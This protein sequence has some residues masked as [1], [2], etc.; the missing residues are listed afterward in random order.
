M[1]KK[2]V[3]IIITIILIVLSS[4]IAIIG[5]N[6]KN[7]KTIEVEAVVKLIG[8]DY[9]VVEDDKGEKY[10]LETNDEYSIGDRVDFL[11]KKIKNKSN[12]IEGTLVK[13]DTI[14]KDIS[15]SINDNAS[16]QDEVNNDK[17]K[18]EED[19]S[20]NDN[21][22]NNTSNSNKNTYNDVSSNITNTISNDNAVITYLTNLNNE[23]EEYNQ[24]K[25]IGKRLKEGFVTV[26]DFLFYDGEIKG[27]TFDE[28]SNEAKIKVL[29][30]ALKIDSKID[31]YFPGYKEE[32]STTTKDVYTNFKSKASA[33]YLDITTKICDEDPDTCEAAK[34]GLRDLKESFS[35]TWDIIKN[36]GIKGLSKLKEW[37]EIWKTV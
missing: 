31:K 19:I 13:I 36:A 25:S 10:S 16:I 3:F 28:L 32:I 4:I 6:M 22:S 33:L 5:I 35:L 18:I 29:E 12:P 20:N 21:N 17:D 24:D 26:V 27:H 2:K 34:E 8:E 9:I 23:L 15:F 1:N 7:N 30:L 37:Y 14:S 11:I